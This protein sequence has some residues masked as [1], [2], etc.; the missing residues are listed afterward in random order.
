MPR[1]LLKRYLPSHDKIREHK[2]LRCLGKLIH[3]PNI[4]HLNRRS[5]SGAFSVGLFMAFMPVPSQM[6]AAALFAVLFRVNLPISVGLVWVSNPITIPPLFYLAYKIGSFLLQVP[7][8]RIDFE[9]SLQWLMH[10]FLAVWQP[11]LLGC[12]VLGTVSALAGNLF[13]RV[14]WRIHV[15]RSWKARKLKKQMQKNAHV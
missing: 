10:E 4:L 15:I 13:I 6:V 8:R 7:I 2:Q 3:D 14:F 12:F 1:R 9:F 5:V 11:V